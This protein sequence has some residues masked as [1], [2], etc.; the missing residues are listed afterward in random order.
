MLLFSFLS[1]Q[2]DSMSAACSNT[3]AALEYHPKARSTGN[4]APFPMHI[5]KCTTSPTTAKRNVF[6]PVTIYSLSFP[7]RASSRRYIPM[8]PSILELL[9]QGFAQCTRIYRI[10]ARGHGCS[11]GSRTV[12]CRFPVGLPF[13]CLRRRGCT[14]GWC[15]YWGRIQGICSF[16]NMRMRYCRAVDLVTGTHD[17]G[18]LP[19][20]VEPEM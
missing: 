6:S 11:I 9:Q 7:A 18:G 16:C 17:G 1:W 15:S 2:V 5:G 14:A 8:S 12:I 10:C 13:F 4:S 3:S 19:N 20:R